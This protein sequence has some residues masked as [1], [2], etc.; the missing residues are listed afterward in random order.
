MAEMRHDRPSL[1]QVWEFFHPKQLLALR[2]IS[3]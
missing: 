1:R 2:V 3:L